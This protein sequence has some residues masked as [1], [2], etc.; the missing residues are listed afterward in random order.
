MTLRISKMEKT[1]KINKQ[2]E[3]QKKSY[4]QSITIKFNLIGFV[5]VRI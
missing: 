1:K 2:V 5:G 4:S 3:L